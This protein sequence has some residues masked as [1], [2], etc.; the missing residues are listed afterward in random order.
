MGRLKYTSIVYN[1]FLFGLIFSGSLS[2]QG[3]FY[4]PIK[5]VTL[6]A[7]F[8]LI[9]VLMFIFIFI[10]IIYS[11]NQNKQNFYKIRIFIKASMLSIGH[12][13]PIT[14]F[15]ITVIIDLLMIALQYLII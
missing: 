2:L 7:F 14:V 11:L 13:N 1:V 5:L 6:N 8:Y 3:A 9:G 15:S 4:N 10:E 12:V